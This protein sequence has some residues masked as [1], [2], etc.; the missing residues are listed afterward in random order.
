MIHSFAQPPAGSLDMTSASCTLRLV[1]EMSRM[2]RLA[3]QSPDFAGLVLQ[4]AAAAPSACTT[5]PCGDTH[6]QMHCRYVTGHYIDVLVSCRI[7]CEGQASAMQS[8]MQYITN[9]AGISND[10]APGRSPR[11]LRR[12]RG[13]AC[14]ERG[15]DV[16]DGT[17]SEL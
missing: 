1:K 4:H 11:V 12:G 3:D 17:R 15:R 6:L 16:A 5:A 7:A 10:I 14:G 13:P 9:V 8:P 2:T